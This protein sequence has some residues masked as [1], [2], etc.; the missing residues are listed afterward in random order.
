MVVITLQA[1]SRV[2]GKLPKG[3]K[4]C[5]KGAKLVLLVTGLCKRKCFYCPLSKEKRNKDVVF[6]NERRVKCY[7]DIIEEA[8][9]INALGTGITG[10]DPMLVPKRTLRYIELIKEVFGEEHHTH[11]YTT[12]EFKRGLVRKLACAGLDEIRF[13]PPIKY[14]DRLENSSYEI[15]IKEA[16]RTNMSVGIEIPSLPNYKAKII[17]LIKRADELGVDFIN[18]NELE[19]SETN[20]RALNKLGYKVKNDI[21]AAVKG[22]EPLA[23]EL[24]KKLDVDI[25]LHY[26]SSAFK[27]SVQLRNRI[28]R[29]AKNIVKDYEIITE[30]ATL[31]KGIIE[32]E[33]LSAVREE[34]I[35]K[36]SIPEKL[37]EIDIARRRLETAP[38]IIVKIAKFLPFPCS[39]VEEYPTA[40]RLEVEREKLN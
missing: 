13:H 31:L 11:L 3:C 23:L 30:D 5:S 16:L 2:I 26:C 25:T 6:A 29:R 8:E 21:S 28:M 14:W 20:Y 9:L 4:Y 17:S 12:G 40:D 32:C 10:G 36:F 39:I 1:G 22:S 19:Y 37:V 34:L 33:N 35:K 7:N 24:M 18:L 15:I 27:D 38:W